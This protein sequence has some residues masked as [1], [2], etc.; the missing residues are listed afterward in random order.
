M[1]TIDLNNIKKLIKQKI[2]FII[3]L[4]LI[5][6]IVF[7]MVV[8]SLW[9]LF[10][11]DTDWSTEKSGSPNTYTKNAKI[12]AEDGISVDKEDLIIKALL[13]KGYTED[14]ISE[15]EEIDKINA[16]RLSEILGRKIKSFKDC[17]PAEILWCANSTYSKYLTNPSQ[18]SYLLNAELVAQYPKIGLEDQDKIDGIIEFKRAV[19]E[20]EEG[21]TEYNTLK[22]VPQEDFDKAFEGYTSNSESAKVLE[23][24]TIDE[25]GNAVVATWTSDGDGGFNSGKKLIPY[26]EMIQQYTLPFQ[27]LWC[28]LVYGQSYDFVKDVATL[29]YNSKIEIGIYDNITETETTTTVTKTQ[30]VYTEPMGEQTQRK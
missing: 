7:I 19:G 8:S 15:M 30:R 14:Q 2:K 18:L 28:L 10:N 11:I 4:L 1:T 17:T 9:E 6:I 13:N 3:I 26:K 20:N 27:Y 23:Y 12:S 16:L 5:I 29:A 22:Y 24:F 25:E 21:E